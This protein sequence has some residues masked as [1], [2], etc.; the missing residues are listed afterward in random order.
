MYKATLQDLQPFKTYDF[1]CK[2]L[3]MEVIGTAS[4]KLTYS[5]G[6][7]T[8]NYEDKPVVLGEDEIVKIEALKELNDI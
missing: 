7:I 2:V 1:K 6:N 3:D 8:Y 5:D 4:I